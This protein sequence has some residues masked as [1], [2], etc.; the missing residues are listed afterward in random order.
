[1][2][3]PDLNKDL[4]VWSE[5]NLDMMYRGRREVLVSGHFEGVF[6]N[7][8]YCSIYAWL[9]TQKYSAYYEP[10]GYLTQIEN[11]Y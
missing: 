1:M 8:I 6:L 9:K 2:K 7:C 5:R 4:L 3:S 11:S 10:V